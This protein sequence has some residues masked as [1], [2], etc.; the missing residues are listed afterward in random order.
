MIMRQWLTCHSF[1]ATWAEKL[2]Q[3]VAE[4]DYTKF[5]SWIPE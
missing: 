4:P 5:E 1:E 2:S 3:Q